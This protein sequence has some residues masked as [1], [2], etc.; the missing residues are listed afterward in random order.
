LKTLLDV[1]ATGTGWSTSLGATV[2]PH[3]RLTAGL[4]WRSGT[5]LTTRG[6]ATGD[7]WAQ[8]AALGVTA[9]SAFGYDAAVQNAFPVGA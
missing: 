2:R 8:F 1:E 7:V 3:E 9:E 5:R 4:A 6:R